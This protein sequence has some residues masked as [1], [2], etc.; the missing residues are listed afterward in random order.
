MD[1]GLGVPYL[2]CCIFGSTQ[3]ESALSSALCHMAIERS[4]AA[5]HEALAVRHIVETP[6]PTQGYWP[7]HQAAP[8]TATLRV[9][10]VP[11]V[12]L[13]KTMHRCAGLSAAA[14][15]RAADR[16]PAS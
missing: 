16:S 7:S 15:S 4:S 13:G 14:P 12:L 5:G 3:L 9:E 10:V 1:S 2:A 11:I 6:K 8:H